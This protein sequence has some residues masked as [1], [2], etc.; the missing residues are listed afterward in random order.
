MQNFKGAIFDMDGTLLDSMP[1]WKRLT[2]GYLKQFDL[3]ITDADY[4]ACEGFSQPQVAD[5]FLARYPQIP[6]TRQQMLD[7]MDEL[8]TARYETIAKPKDGVIAFLERLRSAGVK[9][10]IATLTARRHAEKALRDRDMMKYFEFML[11]IEDVGV[12]KYEPDIYL[13]A[14]RRLGDLAPAECVVFE[15][16]PYAGVTAKRAGFRLCGM[17]EP[18]YAA[19]ESELRAASDFFVERSFDEL[20]GKL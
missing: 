4:A 12:P 2:Q 5:Y 15:D 16:A 20:D 9:M 11:T 18:A 3:H 6:Q 7:G 8:I 1:V 17:A 14:A 19:G 13:E 10:A